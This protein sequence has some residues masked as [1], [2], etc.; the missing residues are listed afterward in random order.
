MDAQ[1]HGTV[2][3]ACPLPNH[4]HTNSS[5]HLQGGGQGAHEGDTGLSALARKGGVLRQEAIARVD[6][7]HVSLL[8]HLDDGCMQ[9]REAHVWHE[10]VCSPGQPLLCCKV[11]ACLVMQPLQTHHRCP[12]RRPRA[13]S[14]GRPP[15]RPH[16]PCTCARHHAWQRLPSAYFSARDVMGRGGCLTRQRAGS[17]VPAAAASTQ[18]ALCRL[19]SQLLHRCPSRGQELAASV[20]LLLLHVQPCTRRCL[21][22]HA[23][24]QQ[25]DPWPVSPWAH[26]WGCSLS[27]AL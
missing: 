3:G 4:V 2:G 24:E 17:S 6:G 18:A 23:V 27:A 12:G 7:V 11:G 20:A 26:L 22:P 15:G 1:H 10:P 8:G 25:L 14:G 5:A 13:G 16:Q 9:A 21:R 19:A